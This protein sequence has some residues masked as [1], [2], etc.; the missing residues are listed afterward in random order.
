LQRAALGHPAAQ[1]ALELSLSPATVKRHFERAYAA[2]GVRD[3]A[4]AVGEAM[5]RGLIT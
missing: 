4:S 1:I 2:L 5:R 3:R